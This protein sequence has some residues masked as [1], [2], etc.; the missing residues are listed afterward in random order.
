M[1]KFQ[2]FFFFSFSW[3]FLLYFLPLI[4]PLK[5]EKF[6]KNWIKNL[7]LG[8][9]FFIFFS[10]VELAI[11]AYNDKMEDQKQRTKKMSNIGNMLIHANLPGS[12]TLMDRYGEKRRLVGIIKRI[13]KYPKFFSILKI[14]ILLKE[15]LTAPTDSGFRAP[16]PDSTRLRFPLCAVTGY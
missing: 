5:I 16:V 3:K 8:C 7:I 11:V 2:L 10:L 1:G 14:I 9:V 15:F 6:W 12:H 4:T 13:R